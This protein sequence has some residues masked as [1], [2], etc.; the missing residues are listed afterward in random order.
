MNK[1]ILIVLG[2]AVVVAFLVAMLVQLSIGGDAPAPENRSVKI[3]VATKDLLIGHDLTENDLAWKEWPEDG[4]M[5]SAVMQRDNESPLNAVQ[6]RLKEPV[7]AGDPL[8]RSSL[9]GKNEGNAVASKLP[10][11]MRAVSIAVS[12][13]SMV[14]GFIGPG[15]YVDVVLTYKASVR[16]DNDE[17]T[18][19]KEMVAKN[20]DKF[21][22]E[23]ILQNVRVLAVD[24][25]FKRG[26]KDDAK[27]GRTVTLAVSKQG[28]E[29]LVLA[30]EIG[31][32]T[33]ILRS[34][35][36]Q[37]VVAQKDWPTVTDARM[38]SIVDEIIQESKKVKKDA[39]VNANVVR[40]YSGET[41]KNVPAQ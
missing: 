21:A 37:D 3:V 28:A 10:A 29:K 38:T 17:I 39:G 33:L 5:S 9:L 8:L 2:G 19:V 22:A 27:V 15:D 7:S 25:S 30:A 13:E 4:V 11:G 14:S 20:L 40:I 1:N 32:L 23:T 34:M 41:L 6:G 16:M 35:G 26:D 18:Q 24:Q 36:D 31:D 12:P